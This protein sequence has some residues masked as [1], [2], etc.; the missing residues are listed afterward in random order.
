MTI[1]E[2]LKALDN[3]GNP[4]KIYIPSFEKELLFK[5]LNTGLQKTL[6]KISSSGL[7]AYRAGTMRLGVF[8]EMLL[9][10]KPI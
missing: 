2:A 1:D 9:E 7:D 4:L 3:D 6:G 5:N 8:E 10:G